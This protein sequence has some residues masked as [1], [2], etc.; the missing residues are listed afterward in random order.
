MTASQMGGGMDRPPIPGAL[1]DRIV[2]GG[3]IVLLG[4]VV[5]SWLTSY[6]APKAAPVGPG[7]WVFALPARVQI[8]AGLAAMAAFTCLGRALWT[9]LP[10]GQPPRLVAILRPIGLG[11]FL[12]G[13]LL[14]LWARWALGAMYGVSTSFAAQLRVGHRLVQRGPYA[15][16]RHPMYLGYWLLL[17][18]VTLIYR[19]WATLVCLVMCLASLYLRA[20]R[21][22][23]TLA[24]AL[25][26]E[27]QAYVARTRFLIPFVY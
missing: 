23:A 2:V 8:G 4:I 11:F 7:R 9:P 17:L 6:Q 21:E 14:V 19:A 22:E 25:G 1:T 13:W 3:L 20:R 18:G 15:F 16:V 26:P 27:W 24:A 10:L 12:A 5:A